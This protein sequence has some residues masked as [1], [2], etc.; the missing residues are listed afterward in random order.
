MYSK[1]QQT[2]A[3]TLKKKASDTQAKTVFYAAKTK[4]V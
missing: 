4:N 3:A 1:D 2:L